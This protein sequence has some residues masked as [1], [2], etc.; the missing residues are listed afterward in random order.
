MD[1][2]LIRTILAK[3]N[4]DKAIMIL[5]FFMKILTLLKYFIFVDFTLKTC[6]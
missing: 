4:E 3:L 2:F 5:F 6:R 1:C